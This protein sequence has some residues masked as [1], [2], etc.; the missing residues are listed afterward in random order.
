MTTFHMRSTAVAGSNTVRANPQADLIAAGLETVPDCVLSC[1]VEAT[2]SSDPLDVPR[3]P[4]PARNFGGFRS[5][6]WLSALVGKPSV[7]PLGMTLTPLCQ[8]SAS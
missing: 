6:L 5:L 7:V 2:Q 8:P 4:P 3:D 1:A